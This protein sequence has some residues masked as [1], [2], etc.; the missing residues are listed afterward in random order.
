MFVVG[1]QSTND[2][3]EFIQNDIMVICQSRLVWLENFA[4]Y[5]EGFEQS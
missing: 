1:K 5:L 3:E 4:V 2:G